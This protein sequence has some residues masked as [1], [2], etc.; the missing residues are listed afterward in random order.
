M[1]ITILHN[2]F[3]ASSRK[4]VVDMQALGRTDVEVVNWYNNAEQSLWIENGGT[5]EICAFPTVVIGDMV[6]TTPTVA[7]V[8]EVADG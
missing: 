2:D 1:S 5:L 8:L 3:D 7:E 6:L 4:F